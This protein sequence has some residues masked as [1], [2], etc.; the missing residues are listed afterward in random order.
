MG[1]S[2]YWQMKTWT[3]LA[4]ISQTSGDSLEQNWGM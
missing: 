4:N 3:I 2:L 1:P